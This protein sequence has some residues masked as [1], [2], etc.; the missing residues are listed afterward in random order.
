MSS[1]GHE[2]Q[3]P[4]GERKFSQRVRRESQLA[5]CR[6]DFRHG[7]LQPQ[8]GALPRRLRK[9]S[10]NPPV[11]KPDG[12]LF[13]TVPDGRSFTDKLYR[14]L[15]CGGGHLQRYSFE[16]I[17]SDIQSGTGLHL[18]EWKELFSSFLFLDKRNF[19]P[20]PLGSLPGPFPRRMRWVGSL[21]S[22]SLAGTRVFLN[23]AARLID[24]CL[25]TRFSRYG[26]ALSFGP[27]RV[28]PEEEPGSANVCMFCG[29]I[30]RAPKERIARLLYRRPYCLKEICYSRSPAALDRAVNIW[31][32][33][34]WLLSPL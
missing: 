31:A 14:L 5:L 3:G 11:L 21:P 27:A 30:R 1:G 23:V 22:W 13:V 6:P 4:R 10:R 34:Y 2:R 19:V 16:G 18:A 12:R 15:F 33:G 32:T 25:P 17:V 9:H 7:H 20:A 8:S 24:R 26:W 29:G 28:T